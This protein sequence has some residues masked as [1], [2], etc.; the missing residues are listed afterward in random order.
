MRKNRQPNHKIKYFE[1]GGSCGQ[2][3]QFIIGNRVIFFSIKKELFTLIVE[4]EE[5]AKTQRF[6][7]ESLWKSNL[8]K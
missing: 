2:T 1:D 6:L 8:P 4:S 3:D 7:F 5:I